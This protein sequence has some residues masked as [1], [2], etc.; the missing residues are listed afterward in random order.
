MGHPE[1]PPTTSVPFICDGWTSHR[2]K[3]VPAARPP[4]WYCA[5]FGPVTRAPVNSAA[6][7]DASRYTDTLCC[8]PASWLSKS[9]TKAFPAVACSVVGSKA[10]AFATTRTDPGGGGADDDAAP[11]N[12]NV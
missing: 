5:F 12:P 3:Y 6:V 7:A 4:T 1:P 10:K 2:K 11:P 9:M 8:T